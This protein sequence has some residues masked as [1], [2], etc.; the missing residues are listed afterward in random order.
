MV[1]INLLPKEI[2]E[3]Q[4]FQNILRMIIFIFLFIMSIFTLIYL[5]RAS[6]L[7]Q[8]N[9]Q[10][11]KLDFELRKL[12][13]IIKEVKQLETLKL[14]LQSRKKLVESL[15]SNGLCYPKFMVSLVKTLPDGVW[16]IELKT[17]T[18]FDNERKIKEI[19][20]SVI[21]NSYDKFSI[22][23]FLANL[24]QSKC[25]RNVTLGKIDITQKDKYELHNFIVDFVYSSE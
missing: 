15:L 17:E 25:F 20:A 9:F 1:S 10:S 18:V 7:S 21:C 13:P 19:K 3:Q 8:L 16:L 12:E 24:E 22:A 6:Y 14:T 2:I 11:S 5:S 4:K 23:N